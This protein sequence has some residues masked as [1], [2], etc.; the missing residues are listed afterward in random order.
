MEICNTRV[1]VA[2]ITDAQ[3][4]CKGGAGTAKMT[5]NR[6]GTSQDPRGDHQRK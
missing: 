6:K 5:F 2:Y 3:I 1:Q 4:N